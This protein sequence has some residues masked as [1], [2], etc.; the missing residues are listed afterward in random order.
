MR[1][2]MLPT[3]SDRASCARRVCISHPRQPPPEQLQPCRL[4]VPSH[5]SCPC[6]AVRAGG[7]PA[8]SSAGQPLAR[9][10]RADPRRGPQRA[11]WQQGGMGWA[12]AVDGKGH[13]I[14]LYSP[15]DSA[16]GGATG[17]PAHCTALLGRRCGSTRLW[18]HRIDAR[19]SFCPLIAPELILLELLLTLPFLWI[20]KDLRRH[21]TGDQAQSQGHVH[22]NTPVLQH[23]SSS[24]MS[25]REQ[26]LLP[27]PEPSPPLWLSSPG[28]RECL[29]HLGEDRTIQLIFDLVEAHHLAGRQYLL[30]LRQILFV[31]FACLPPSSDGHATAGVVPRAMCTCRA[32]HHNWRRSAHRFRRRSAQHP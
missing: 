25:T 1:R 27:P 12:D 21:L 16:E 7:L 18:L 24:I 19:L 10:V 3:I 8:V 6:A 5:P 32:A 26:R 15:T 29:C 17:R 4:P 28:Q 23:I 13:L 9:G 20:G 31:V 11:G 30:E 22:Y 14:F 2:A